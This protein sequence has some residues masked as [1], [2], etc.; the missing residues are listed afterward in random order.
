MTTDLPRHS[1][2]V[3][4]IVIDG[5]G[6]ALLI[7]RPENGRW[8]PPGGVLELGETFQ[9]GVRREVKE[10]TGLDVEPDELTGVYKNMARAVVAL[11]FPCHILAA[12]SPPI[13]RPMP[14][15]GHTQTKCQPSPPKSSRIES[16]TRTS[17]P[18]NRQSGSTTGHIWWTDGP[19][20]Q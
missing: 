11:T 15:S 3:A 6:R 5:Q 17:T 12:N 20:F 16:S 1:V 8:E 19:R 9:A 18:H 7:Q 13:P 10:E 14:S 4:G 2:A